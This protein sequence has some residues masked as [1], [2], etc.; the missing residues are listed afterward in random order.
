MTHQNISPHVAKSAANEADSAKERADLSF[1]KRKVKER[2][3]Y[4]IALFSCMI[5][6]IATFS[7]VGI[8]L[9][10]G[11]GTISWEFLTEAPTH[12]MSEGGIFPAIVG[13]FFLVMYMSILTVPL[14]TVIAFYLSE[15]AT[16][17]KM[18]N[19]IMSAVRTLAAVPSIVFGLFG[20]SFFVFF[21]G[22]NIDAAMGIDPRE[23]LFNK[24]CLLWAAC[25][26][27]IL[28]LP[29]NIVAVT[30]ALKMVSMEQRISGY[31][32]GMSKWEVIRYIVFP[33]SWGG[34]I[35]GLVLSVS[36]GAGEVA[37]ILFVGAAY[38]LPFL[39][40]D[41]L[42]QFMELGYHIYIMTT[43]S[44]NVEKTLP[45]QYATTL[46]LLTLT[47]MLNAFGQ[48]FRYIHRKKLKQ[49]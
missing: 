39:P 46:V 35:T 11:I 5:I 42:S 21:I 41:P 36:R 37:P 18:Y 4:R 2:W 26:M 20:L 33:Q 47:L 40:A 13:T 16:H 1:N 29:T 3:F 19:I 12:G 15:I 45:I 27:G 17:G 22:E 30:E 14:G 44:F 34:I 9:V 49:L 23:P 8:I 6:F 24:P 7:I 38:F 10:N 43:Q 31:C 28:T 48:A 25:T 32:M